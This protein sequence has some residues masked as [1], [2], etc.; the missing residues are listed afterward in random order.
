MRT[1]FA[2]LLATAVVLA[3]GTSLLGP[4]RAPG[5]ARAPSGDFVRAD[6]AGGDLVIASVEGG[7]QTGGYRNG[8]PVASGVDMPLIIRWQPRNRAAA[9]GGTGARLAN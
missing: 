8:R 6:A 9:S 7:L 3:A 2:S 5:E 1:L 4:G